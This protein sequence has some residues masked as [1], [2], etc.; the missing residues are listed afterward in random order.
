M[1]RGEGTPARYTECFEFFLAPTDRNGANPRP[2]LAPHVI[3]NSWG[4]PNSEGC[5]DPNILKTVV[6][7]VRAAGIL[8]VVSAGNEGPGCSTVGVP[9]I[10]EAS[11]AVGATTI[12]D[13]IAVFSSRGTVTADGSNRLKPDIS[14]PGVAIRVAEKVGGYSRGF[15]GTSASAPEVSGAAALLLSAAPE[16]IDD[17]AATADLLRRTAVPLADGETCGGISGTAVPNPI[18]GSGR[19]DVFEAVAVA[20]PVGRVDPTQAASRE[21]RARDLPPRP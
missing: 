2:D 17:P 5:T 21:R 15:S 12:T 3:N 16:L 13:A 9:A 18:F 11:F 8:V 4:C 7:N 10:Y 19:L 1:D 20:A 14:A 6:E